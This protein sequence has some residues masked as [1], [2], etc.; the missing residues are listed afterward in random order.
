MT[1]TAD[2]RHRLFSRPSARRPT[3]PW[4]RKSGEGGGK[5]A[6]KLSPAQNG[7]TSV[8]PLRP[9][10]LTGLVARRLPRA[11]VTGVA[12]RA[13]HLS[14]A[15]HQ[16]ALS[17]GGGSSSG[18]ARNCTRAI[19]AAQR[20]EQLPADAIVHDVLV[21]FP[22]GVLVDEVAGNRE[23]PRL[24]PQAQVA[25]DSTI[26]QAPA[27]RGR[28]L[29]PGPARSRRAPLPGR[30][31]PTTTLRI[32]A[33]ILP[34]PPRSAVAATLRVFSARRCRAPSGLVC[35]RSRPTASWP[36]ATG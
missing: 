25:P 30:S 8:P 7:A 29:R 16:G 28:R 34:C 12:Y 14:H 22:V 9:R 20:G 6:D 31:R 23:V 36:R 26:E 5:A 10:P 27:A 35:C 18:Q 24:I 4:R 2:A 32:T 11:Q 15:S 19:S 21:V 1:T 3:A 33:A 17:D 13:P